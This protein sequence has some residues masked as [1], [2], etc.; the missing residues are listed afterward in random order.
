MTTPEKSNWPKRRKGFTLIELL[1]VIGIIALMATLVIPAS[2]TMLKG[3]DLTQG[4]NKFVDE[5]DLARQTALSQNREVE[6]RLYQ[7]ADPNMPGESVGTTSSWKFRAI[8]LFEVA[9]SGSSTP[10]DKAATLPASVIVDKGASANQNTTLSSI[11]SLAQSSPTIPTLYQAPQTFNTPRAGVN[12]NYV[13]FHFESDGSTDLP[14]TSSWF[15][16]LHNINVGDELS[17]PP[18][19]FFTIQ[20]DPTDGHVRTYNP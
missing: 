1:V 8:Q 16:T 11:T 14:P 15:I 2:V 19:N 10:V 3:T 18:Q 17:S 20:I 6:V 12:Y 9:D 13:S 7:Y 4:S 5:L